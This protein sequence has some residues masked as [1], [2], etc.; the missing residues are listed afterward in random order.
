M[1]SLS[2]GDVLHVDDPSDIIEL[3]KG[4]PRP[5]PAAPMPDGSP[6]DDDS[7]LCWRLKSLE[8]MDRAG[9]LPMLWLD[10]GFSFSPATAGDTVICGIFC[11]S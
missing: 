8:A 7:G 2:V 10:D 3:R 5:E 9:C 6:W 1:L 11:F 4:V